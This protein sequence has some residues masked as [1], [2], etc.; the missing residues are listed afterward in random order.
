MTRRDEDELLTIEEVLERFPYLKKEFNWNKS[1]VGILHS[2]G[3]LHGQY[4]KGKRLLLVSR[5]SVIL[6]INIYK[7][8]VDRI[9]HALE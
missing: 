1:T 7:T 4:I 2:I 3:L 9:K 8:D 5:Q 6:L